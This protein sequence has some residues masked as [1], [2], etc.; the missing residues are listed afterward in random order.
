MGTQEEEK[1]EED[2]MRAQALA[3]LDI[4]FFAHPDKAEMAKDV[5]AEII[6]TNNAAVRCRVRKF[7]IVQQAFLQAKTN[8]MVKVGKL[9]ESTSQWC[10]GLVL[11]AYDERQ[12]AF[13][14]RQ[15]DSAMTDM[16]LPEHEEE[17]ATFFRLCVDLRSLNAKTVPDIF[18]LPR[19]DDLL[20]SIPRGCGRYS[21]S[22]ICDAFFTCEVQENHRNKLAFKTH[23][24]HLQFACLPQ[25]FIN[26]PSIFCRLI[27]RTFREM[28]R[29][30][31]S[32]YIDDVLNHTDD[33]GD[34]V[35]IQQDMYDRLRDNNLTVKVS[36]THLNFP[37][38]KF[39]GH[40]LTKEG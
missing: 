15:G 3:N 36:K 10:H 1:S 21:I 27:A 33:F 25:R 6:T 30:K 24:R 31:F 39:L 23:D 32:A 2:L 37:V 26:S 8:L 17:V 16:F 38:V 18:P 35:E 9:E 13:M 20:E 7:S 11:V 14:D 19:I 5:V 22:D 12:R 34:H 4:F 29:S 40:I 28:D